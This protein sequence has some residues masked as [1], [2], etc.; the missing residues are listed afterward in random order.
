MI[1]L[2]SNILIRY[3]A[4]DHAGQSAR[5]TQIIEGQLSQDSPGFISSIV[6]VEMVWTLM[7]FYKLKQN[8]IM[9]IIMEL[10]NADDIQLEHREEIWRAYQQVSSQTL[11]F[12]DALLGAIHKKSGC[13]YT[14]TFDKKAVNSDL[15]VLA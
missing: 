15:F 9:A 8:A 4:Q 7:R 2:D 10:M 1:G 5:A 6:L 12:S 11:D 14:L 13:E 3:F